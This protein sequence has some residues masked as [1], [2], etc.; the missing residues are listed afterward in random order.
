MRK[1]LIWVYLFAAA[2]ALSASSARA[3]EGGDAGQPGLLSFNVGASI[4]V[5]I[6]FVILL[7][8]LKKAAWGN[9]LASLKGREDRIRND[10][11]AGEEARAKAEALL[12]EHAAKIAGAEQQVRDLIAKAT[13]DAEKIATNI[14]TQAQADGEAQIQKARTEIQN[15]QRDAIR[16]VYE[17][18]AD[19]AT[20]VAS[21]IIRRELRPED[22]VDLVNQTLGQLE[23]LGQQN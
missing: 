21:K 14:K 18:A 22:Q 11:R 5:L 23:A 13:I 19:L 9:V 6:S 7:V 10:I 2:M 16:Q 15:A 3:A 1:K 8:I 20:E 12:K 4:W 17:K